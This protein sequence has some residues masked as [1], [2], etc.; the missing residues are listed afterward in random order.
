MG[1]FHLLGLDRIFLRQRFFLQEYVKGRL[2]LFGEIAALLN[3]PG[4]PPGSFI[5]CK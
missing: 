3:Q 2:F 1:R 4:N 5:P